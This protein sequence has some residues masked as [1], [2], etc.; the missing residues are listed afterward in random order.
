MDF[1]RDGLFQ[2]RSLV[3]YQLSQWADMEEGAHTYITSE[4]SSRNITWNRRKPAWCAVGWPLQLL[5]RQF[6]GSV[7]LRAGSQEEGLTCTECEVRAVRGQQEGPEEFSTYLIVPSPTLTAWLGWMPAK[8]V[9]SCLVLS[10]ESWGAHR[11][12][13]GCSYM[14]NEDSMFSGF[15]GLC[16]KQRTP[17]GSLGAAFLHADCV[18]R[19]VE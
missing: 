18:L 2:P 16:V 7:G 5:C 11:N 1:L 17:E 13:L 10:L 9:N 15:R 12:S 14:W 3:S 6:Q 8:G 4:M 19:R